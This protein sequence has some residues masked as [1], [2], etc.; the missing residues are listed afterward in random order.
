MN[1]PGRELV[2]IAGTD[3]TEELSGHRTLVAAHARAAVV[4]G[5]APH[6]FCVGS[7]PRIE[8]SE[9]GTL[10]RIPSPIPMRHTLLA[11]AHQ[12]MLVA[13]VVRHLAGTQGPHVIHSFGPWASTGVAASRILARRGVQAIPIASV[14]TTLA[15]ESG[16][17]VGG[18]TE[19]HGVRQMLGY[20][21]SD[22]WVR[23]IAAPAER[24]GYRRSARLLVNYDSVG[25]LIDAACG[26]GL[27][28]RRLSYAAPLAFRADAADLAA[29]PAAIARLQPK[30][31]PL[32]VSVSRHDPRKG[33][34]ILLGALAGLAAAKVPARA[35]LVGPGPL[36]TAHEAL[37]QELGLSASVAIT[38]RVDDVLPYLQ[39]ADVFVLPSLEEGS[40]SMSLLEALQTGAAIVASDVDGIPED[41]TNERDALLVA[42]GDRGALEAA[43]TRVCTD[44]RLRT[45][46]QT[47]ARQ[48]HAERFAATH[49][50]AALAA[51]YAELGLTS[52]DSLASGMTRQ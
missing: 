6:V 29:V 45:R 47:R 5:F 20:R 3:P 27:D 13:A 37:V 50:V 25:R 1:R 12:P 46:L 7:P 16:A 42:P 21:T 14:Y 49:L 15:H 34:D 39:H 31:A 19:P 40:G 36:L 32:I 28:I 48:I 24:R 8:L 35:C 18:L 30:G 43:L 41:V 11:A 51:T 10:H 17:K 33:V 9:L 22:G 38:G 26:P 52:G 23:T 4:P 44:A 2:M